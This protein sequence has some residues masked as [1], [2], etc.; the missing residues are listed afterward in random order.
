MQLIWR[1]QVSG[2]PQIPDWLDKTLFT[3]FFIKIF[4]VAAEIKARD[5]LKWEHK[6]DCTS[7]V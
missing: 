4:T 2:C 7:R 3:R 6:L 5:R 1:N